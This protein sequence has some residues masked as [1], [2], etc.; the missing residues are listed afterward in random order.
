MV[1]RRADSTD[2]RLN[3][4]Y[5]ADG[6]RRFVDG[7]IRHPRA[8]KHLAAAAR[9]DGAA[10]AQTERNKRKLQPDY[11]PDDTSAANGG[12]GATLRAVLRRFLAG[13]QEA[14]HDHGLLPPVGYVLS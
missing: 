8:Q 10:T 2:A 12:G 1:M 5:W 4:A 6:V 14:M 13:R 3:V 7:T 11:N 9:S